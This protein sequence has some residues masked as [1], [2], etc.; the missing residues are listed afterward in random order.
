MTL[1]RSE[2]AQAT[3]HTLDTELATVAYREFGSGVP[4]V[5]IHGFP[6]H[7]ATFR[8]LV[9]ELRD[10]YRCI[11][12]EMPG[13]GSS[14]FKNDGKPETFYGMAEIL[15]EAIQQ[16]QLER[17]VLVGFD[18]G[19]AMGRHIAA[20]EKDRVSAMILM[21][22]EIPGSRPPYLPFFSKLLRLPGSHGIMRR[23]LRWKRFAHSNMIMGGCYY[24][25]SRLND[26]FW[27]LYLLPVL[28]DDAR[29]KMVVGTLRDFDWPG[30]DGLTQ[31]HREITAPVGFIWGRN[32]TIFPEAE[33]RQMSGQFQH[34]L[35]FA[36]VENAKLM[37]HEE[38]P[39]QVAEHIRGYLAQALVA[40]A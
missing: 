33:A 24:D 11:L 7:G 14:T 37:V 22:T 30:I 12:L 38:Q 25:R 8:E 3:V 5:M 40:A 19:G 35:G 23:M 28:D 39:Q 4:L 17:Y 31:I 18:S 6:F 9:G 15:R 2:Y 13:L 32:C 21:N 29:F 10:S 34:V 26:E 20:K 16:L 27:Q 36:S 1:S